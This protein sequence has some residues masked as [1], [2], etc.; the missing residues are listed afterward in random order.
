M[1]ELPDLGAAFERA[2]LIDVAYALTDSPVGRLLL[3]ATS[4]GLVRVAYLHPQDGE[5]QVLE[6]LA[7]ALS[8]RVLAAPGRLDGVRRELDE[9]FRG[10]R[11]AFETPLDWR[12]TRPGFM[13]RVLRATGRIPYGGLS[14]YRAL[15]AAAGSPRAF[16]AAGNA[17]G[18]NPLPIVVPCHRVLRSDGAF[19]G[20]TGG[21]ERKRV[22]LELEGHPGDAAH[23]AHSPAAARS[24]LTLSDP[25]PMWRPAATSR[26]HRERGSPGR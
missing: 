10:E 12:L 8:P 16:R 26:G 7:R 15:A 25:P 22:L 3:A 18:A 4:H 14:S 24:P 5:Q 17:L 20:Y 13:R 2:G 9:Y 6:D 21:P 23:D 19:G 11:R 1:S